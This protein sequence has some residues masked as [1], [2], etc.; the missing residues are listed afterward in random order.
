MGQT[1][2][3]YYD[4]EDLHGKYQYVPLSQI[5]SRKE[6]DTQTDGHLLSGVKRSILLA[7][8]KEGLRE[9]N[10]DIVNEQLSFEVTVPNSLVWTL[11]QDYVD[12][13]NIFIIQ[14]DT[15][16]GNYELYPLDENPNMSTA[17]GYLQDNE[18]ELLYDHEGD[19]L[20]ADSFNA[21]AK[22]FGHNENSTSRYGNQPTKDTSKYSKY[23]GFVVDKRR[24]VIVF[25]SNIADKE[26]VIRYKSDGLQAQLDDGEVY[27]HKH[28]AKP[29]LDYIF[30]EILIGM[31]GVSE[32]RIRTARTRFLTSRHQAVLN[33]SGI[34]LMKISKA[35]NV[36]TKIF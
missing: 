30:S 36:S 35:M 24:G 1:N 3:E 29:L 7:F 32:S 11:P 23:G 4:N 20:E 18:A 34:S 14:R 8:A 12:D 28:L 26:V 6:L 2:Q 15:N 27:L 22:P 5:I 33:M 31:K 17:I 10:F 21:I 9:L 19:I 13:I 16:T 25:T